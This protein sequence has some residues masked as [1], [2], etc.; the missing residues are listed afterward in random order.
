VSAANESHKAATKLRADLLTSPTLARSVVSNKMATWEQRERDRA[1]EAERQA[2]AKVQAE[3]DEKRLRLAEK[4]ENVGDK[5]TASAIL[6]TIGEAPTRPVTLPVEAQRPTPVAGVSMRDNWR[7]RALP[8]NPLG[9][10]I[11]AAAANPGLEVFLTPNYSALNQEARL[12]K[13]RFSIPGFEAWNDR[14][15][16]VRT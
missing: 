7:A 14:G 16:S 2:R 15:T 3:E 11:K 10:L 4:A 9:D 8:G 13:Q 1:A 5:E 12:K 6:D